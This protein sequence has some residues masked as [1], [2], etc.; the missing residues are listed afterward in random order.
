MTQMKE[1]T[2][3]SF[4]FCFISS[5]LN[6]FFFHSVLADIC[7]KES[8]GIADSLYNL[9]LIGQ[10]CR[11]HLPWRRFHLSYE[12]LLYTHASMHIN[13]CTFLADLFFC[14][15]GSCTGVANSAANAIKN[16]KEKLDGKL[17]CSFSCFN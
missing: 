5:F 14:F 7:L 12:D 1:S 13:I 11:A 4:L 9:R 2:K 10:F 17:V 3:V 16:A 8:I 6:N 15:E